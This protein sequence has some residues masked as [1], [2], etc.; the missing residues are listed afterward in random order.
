MMYS[1]S[2]ADVSKI[3]KSIEIKTRLKLGEE[4]PDSLGKG[5]KWKVLV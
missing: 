3:G 4:A 2:F 5:E 1:F